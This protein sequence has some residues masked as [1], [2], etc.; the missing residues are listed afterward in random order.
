MKATIILALFF[1]PVI[2]KCEN[3]FPYLGGSIL[4]LECFR[5]LPHPR[6]SFLVSVVRSSYF[7]HNAGELNY[8]ITRK[9]SS[10]AF[11]ACRLN[12]IGLL[13]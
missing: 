6:L 7:R 9:K 8:Y 12:V 11:A 2:I 3:V 10:L 1:P 5:W 4:C 13:A